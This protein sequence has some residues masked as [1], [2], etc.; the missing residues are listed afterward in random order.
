LGSGAKVSAEGAVRGA[1]NA[2]R[3]CPD[4]PRTVR[5]HPSAAF[6]ART[7]PPMNDKP[8]YLVFDIETVA[9]G[10]LIQ[11]V[12]YPD[13]K[14]LTPEQA[15][16]KQR[17]E[18]LEKS[19]GKSD[20]IPFTFQL[21]VS[22]A[23]AK[24]AQDFSLIDVITLDRPKFRPQV[25]ARNF[26]K[27]WSAYGQPTLVTFNG[28]FF[29]VPV[30]ELCCYRYGIPV[31]SWFNAQGNSYNQPRNRFNTTAHLDLQDFLGNQGATQINGGLNLCAQLL[32]KPG[33]MDTKGNMVQDLWERGERERIDDYCMCDALD[34]YFVFL[35]TRVVSGVITLER[36]RQLVEHARKW[37][38]QAAGHNLALAE[39]LRH[40]RFWESVGD[41]GD[42]FT[43]ADV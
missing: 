30:L 23:I 1:T 20:F 15:V 11:R 16:A 6:A 8:A 9:D 38:E 31:P 34:T 22:I 35:R 21:P 18:L 12:R 5:S 19:G 4:A 28:R 41:D 32:G 26:W 14:E 29:D 40:F 42:A 7:L 37:I 43:P 39:Y 24:V 25:I 27:G 2:A 3:E 33:K 10:R 13:L 36:E 17:A